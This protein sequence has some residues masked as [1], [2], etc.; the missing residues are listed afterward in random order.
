MYPIDLGT[1]ES[2]NTRPNVTSIV[3]PLSEKTGWLRLERLQLSPGPNQVG[4]KERRMSGALSTTKAEFGM[5]VRSALSHALRGL[6]ENHGLSPQEAWE[7]ILQE[8]MSKRSSLIEVAEAI[9]AG[10]SV[11]YHYNAPV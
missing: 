3:E 4:V 5:D 11:V 9:V 6:A 2:H 7:W 10:E 1:K 8:A